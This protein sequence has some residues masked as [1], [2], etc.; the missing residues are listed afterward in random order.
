M[1][2]DILDF[3][4][5]YKP[6]TVLLRRPQGDPDFFS[7]WATQALSQEQASR[8]KTFAFTCII[9]SLLNITSTLYIVRSLSVS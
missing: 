5:N 8:E 7:G 4:S 6:L 9:I 1:L 2:D 3:D